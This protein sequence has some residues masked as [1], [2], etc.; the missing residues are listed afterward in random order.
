M[1]ND[2]IVLQVRLNSKRLPGKLILPLNGGTIFE[3]VLKRLS[4]AQIPKGV[5]VATTN[6]T[7]PVIKE[8]AEAHGASIIIGSED[9]VLSRF[10]KSVKVFSIDNVIRATGDNPLV[11]IEYIDR[12]LVLHRTEGSDLTTYPDLPYGTGIE[13]IKADVLVDL[14][15]L[16]DDPYEREHI[17]QY[18]YRNEKKYRIVRGTPDPFLSR[19]DIRLT[20]DTQNDYRRMTDIYE[21]LY[22][23]VPIKLQEV[24]SYIDKGLVRRNGGETG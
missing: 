6:D 13:V 9:D 1:E 22:R 3:H 20:V 17:T 18:I 19:P 12:A 15:R 24:I 14:E 10:I 2:Y 7:E 16:T 5:I 11:S 8:T 21:K 4:A 23:G